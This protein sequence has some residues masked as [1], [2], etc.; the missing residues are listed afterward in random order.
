MTPFN[1]YY[2][3]GYSNPDAY[4]FALPTGCDNWNR[5]FEL[6]PDPDRLR[7]SVLLVH[8]LSDGPY[9][10]RALAELFFTQGLHV[11]CLRVPGHGTTPGGLLS[12]TR[13][14]WTAAVEMAAGHVSRIAGPE[15]PFY[16]GGYSN[17][18]ALVLRYVLD[19]LEQTGVRL[20]RHVF[21]LSPAIGVHPSATASNWHKAFSFLPG[22]DRYKWLSIEPEYDPFKYN[23]FPM[24]AVDQVHQLSK[25]NR[26][27]I[28][29]LKET[30]KLAG[31]PPIL[32]FQSVLDTTVM[33]RDLIEQ[34][35]DELPAPSGPQ[36]ELVLIDIN[37]REQYE[38]FFDAK[39]RDVL[40][41]LDVAD[42]TPAHYVLT[43]ITNQ[44][45]NTATVVARSKLPGKSAYEPASPL[46]LEWPSFIYS[47]SH[48][49]V[50]FRPSD[51]VYGDPSQSEASSPLRLGAMAPRGEKGMLSLSLDGLLRLR[52]NVF[53]DYMAHRLREVIGASR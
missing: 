1:R 15:R 5:S 14:D 33:V 34:L 20:P 25:A 45:P 30:G 53:F 40:E 36:S 18:G 26:A 43:L 47:Q 24:N 31:L 7:G 48:V 21:L 32:T 51:P 4:T 23:S 28:L 12:A 6:R 13:H 8:G 9:S 3:D 44:H 39:S 2:P 27:Q 16:L 10:M 22:L 38:E 41:R 52:Y 37:R 46:D 11:T 17:G 50:P 19:A 29:R 49:S 35:Y 42:K